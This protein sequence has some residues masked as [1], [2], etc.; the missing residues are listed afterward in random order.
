MN[1]PVFS[2]TVVQGET[3]ILRLQMI[4]DEGDVVDI[5][6]L[7]GKYGIEGVLEHDLTLDEVNNKLIIEISKDTTATFEPGMYR[8]ECRILDSL[9]KQCVLFIGDLNVLETALE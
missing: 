4:T 7:S 8:H 2:D 3:L 9:G 1:Y 5:T 6:D